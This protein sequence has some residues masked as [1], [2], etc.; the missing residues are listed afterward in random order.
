MVGGSSDCV[1]NE[2][3]SDVQPRLDT[4]EAGYDEFHCI[5]T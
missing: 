4:E 1:C 3:L 2:L 5:L